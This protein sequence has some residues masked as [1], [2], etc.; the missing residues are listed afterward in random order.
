M[1]L[2]QLTLS[3]VAFALLAGNSGAQL[4]GNSGAQTVAPRDPAPITLDAVIREALANNPAIQSARENWEA[5]KARVPQA[6]AWDDPKVSFQDAAG[7]F[8]SVPGNAFADQML[9]A[10]QMIP[11]SG[12]NLAGGRAADAEAVAAYE[13]L[14]RT[15]LDVQ[16]AA[17]SAYFRLGDAYAQI[18]LNRQNLVSLQQIELVSRSKYAVGGEGAVFVLSAETECGKLL[19]MSRDLELQ[20][21]TQQSKLNVV[22]GRDAFAPIGQP[23]AEPELPP[24][25]SRETLEAIMFRSRPEI[26]IAAAKVRQQQ[27]LLQLAHR[28]WIP[29][30]ALGVIAQRYN[31]AAQGVSEVDAVVSFNIPWVNARKYSAGVDEA[32]HQLQAAEA[33]L[34]RARQEA[35]GALREAVENLETNHHHSE[36]FRDKLIPQAQQVFEA[37]QLEYEAGKLGFDDWIAAERTL[38]D[39]EAEEREHL[40]KYE[41]AY[42]DLQAVVGQSLLPSIKNQ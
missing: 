4:A 23:A 21:A 31:G 15:E 17:M 2:Y 41:S 14:R 24:A 42:A 25:P 36:L 6:R 3:F 18:D 12:K 34:E 20:L 10:E 27:A 19:E 8:V 35:V 40:T 22:L 11:V 16:A 13:Q 7:R 9:S 29:D 33:D 5:M 38:R 26:L 1:H 28:Q 39:L 32:Q 30:P 37:S